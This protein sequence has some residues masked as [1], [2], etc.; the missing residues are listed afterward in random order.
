M[1][2]G[3]AD[4]IELLGSGRKP[5]RCAARDPSPCFASHCS[6]RS[7]SP[8]AIPSSSSPSHINQRRVSGRVDNM[9]GCVDDEAVSVDDGDID[10]DCHNSPDFRQFIHSMAK[11]IE[12]HSIG[13]AFNY[14]NLRFQTRKGKTILSDVTGSISRGELLGI[15]GGSGVGKSTFVN[16]L[17]GK[18][19]AASGST[20]KIN[21]WE[22]DM[23]K[24]RKLIGYVP[25][26]DIILPELTVREN[27]LHSARIRLPTSWKDR[28]IQDHVDSLIACLQ[29]AHVQHS[30]VGD[31]R[32]PVI[33]GGQRKRVNI[34]IE[35]AAAPMAIFLDEP[36]SGLVRHVTISSWACVKNS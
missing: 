15:M 36:T 34:G 17:M 18:Q 11:T 16:T 10:E 21:G 31:A 14:K 33:S 1:G 8:C 13:L 4:H 29:L 7:P 30:R 6:E 3:T 26:D 28:A 2:D 20:L 19:R 12:T 25:Q 32:K 9:D 23:S 24:Y 35:L 27:I 5:D 22:K